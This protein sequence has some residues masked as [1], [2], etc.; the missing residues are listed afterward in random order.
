VVGDE[1]AAREVRALP[2]WA[3]R[4]ARA[5]TVRTDVNVAIRRCSF[6]TSSRRRAA[7]K[8]TTGCVDKAR[9]N[10]VV[11]EANRRRQLH[12]SSFADHRAKADADRS[13]A[14]FAPPP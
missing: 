11:V 13:R 9:R 8:D 3:I 1:L 7:E 14:I 5:A 12:T 10:D 2:G 6:A 4:R